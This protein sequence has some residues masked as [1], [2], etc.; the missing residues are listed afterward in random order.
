MDQV[1][2]ASCALH[3]FLI[4]KAKPNR[5][6]D[7][8]IIANENNLTGSI[9]DDW[10]QD[11]TLQGLQP[12]QGRNASTEAKDCRIAYMQYFNGAGSVDWQEA[13]I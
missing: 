8:L 13:M 5:V 11:P 7:N 3:N 1:V 10:R 9:R 4:K 2:L 12:V 6:E